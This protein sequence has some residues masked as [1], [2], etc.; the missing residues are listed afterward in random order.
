MKFEG[1]MVFWYA[2]YFGPIILVLYCK[3]T[4]SFWKKSVDNNVDTS[5]RTTYIPVALGIFS[6]FKN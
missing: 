3:T 4:E 6:Y 2:K 1:Q 5:S